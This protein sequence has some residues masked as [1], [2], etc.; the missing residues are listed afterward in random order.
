M[1]A[2]DFDYHSMAEIDG[3]E[4]LVNENGEP[5]ADFLEL[6]ELFERSVADH[7]ATLKV[8]FKNEQRIAEM[9]ARLKALHI[10]MQRGIR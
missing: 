9:E 10:A 7:R 1:S 6:L 5:V 8:N 4:H 3:R 2:L